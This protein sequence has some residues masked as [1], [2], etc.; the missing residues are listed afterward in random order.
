MTTSD[1]QTYEFRVAAHLDD[2]WS[3][4]IGL[5]IVRHDDGS[6]TFTGPVA[7]QAQLHGILAT[8]RDIGVPL[9]SVHLVRR[10][11]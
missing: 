4:W 9:L 10:D 3:A 1:A 5:P 2:H 11:H 6:S 8:L 7:D